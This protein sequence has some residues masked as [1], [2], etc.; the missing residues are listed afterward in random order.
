M[1]R[2]GDIEFGFNTPLHV[3]GF[4]KGEPDEK[5]RRRLYI[6]N[7][8]DCPETGRRRLLG[9]S[10]LDVGRDVVSFQYVTQSDPER[11]PINYYLDMGD[12]TEKKLGLAIVF[13]DPLDVGRGHDNVMTSL[14]NPS[15][16]VSKSTGLPITADNSVSVKQSSTQMPKGVSEK[17]MQSK[18]G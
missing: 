13:D 18:A 5:G 8:A 14:R 1:T 17:E 15:M 9:L 10:E 3:P 4:I 11:R 7:F 16:F 2:E 12:W 6:Q